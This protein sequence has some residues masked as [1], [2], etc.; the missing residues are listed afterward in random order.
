VILVDS[1]VLIR[2]LGQRT[3]HPAVQAL[4]DVL[5]Q[6]LAF[7]ICPY[8]YQ[9][10]LQG[11]RDE[12][13]FRRVK[14]YLDTQDC[15]WLPSSLDTFARAAR[16]YWDL[17]HSGVTIRSTIDVLIAL[18]AIEHDAWLLHDDRDFDAIAAHCPEL[19]IHRRTQV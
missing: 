3:N 4:T 2:F 18:T 13:T 7:A 8:V 14:S 19:K 1:S 10:V 9:E 12:L 11:V 6:D 15:L 16:L 17:R 5:D